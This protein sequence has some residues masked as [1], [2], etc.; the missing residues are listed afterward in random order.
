MVISCE[1]SRARRS[2]H[3]PDELRAR[4]VGRLGVRAALAASASEVTAVGLSG[5]GAVSCGSPVVGAMVG[6]SD[7][8]GASVGFVGHNISS[9]AVDGQITEFAALAVHG[10]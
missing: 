10:W 8:V 6:K 7:T 5:V 3:R 2:Q 4:R 9:V 1:S